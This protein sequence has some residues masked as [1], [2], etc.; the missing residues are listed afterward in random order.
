M[1]AALT[2]SFLEHWVALGSTGARRAGSRRIPDYQATLVHRARSSQELT[3]A[4]NSRR[5]RKEDVGN[6]HHRK[7]R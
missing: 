5:T 4:G 7:P 2:D 3:G 1:W 6:L